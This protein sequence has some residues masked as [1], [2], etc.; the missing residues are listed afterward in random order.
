MP[1]DQ[2]ASLRRSF[3]TSASLNAREE[4]RVMP[5]QIEATSPYNAPIHNVLP[6]IIL[7]PVMGK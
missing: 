6:P 2:S 1:D 7:P 4:T 5:G 3:V